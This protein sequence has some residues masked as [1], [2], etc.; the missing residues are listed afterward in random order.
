MTFYVAEF[1]RSK[2]AVVNFEMIT[3]FRQVYIFLILR[4]KYICIF[5]VRRK[6]TFESYAEHR[7]VFV[8]CKNMGFRYSGLNRLVNVE[9][10]TYPFIH[11]WLQENPSLQDRYKRRLPPPWDP[12]AFE[13]IHDH[14]RCRYKKGRLRVL[15]PSVFL[16]PS[17]KLLYDAVSWWLRTTEDFTPCP[18]DY[19]FNIKC[20]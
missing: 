8:T 7:N 10:I 20:S 2:R 5:V 1:F 19:N 16:W 18:N 4:M 17:L 3:S 15:F 14:T 12:S 9:H 13:P 11:I 6:S